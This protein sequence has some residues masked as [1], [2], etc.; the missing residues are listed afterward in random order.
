M[1]GSQL[2]SQETWQERA[3]GG[4]FRSPCL[5]LLQ[6]LGP[7]T[8][9]HQFLL[10]GWHALERG[11]ALIFSGKGEHGEH[12]LPGCPPSNLGSFQH[13]CLPIIHHPSPHQDLGLQSWFNKPWH[14]SG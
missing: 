1:E 8:S 11:D 3:A 12:R 13:P 2:Q 7:Q 9:L 10:A 4:I 14:L 5:D 6:G